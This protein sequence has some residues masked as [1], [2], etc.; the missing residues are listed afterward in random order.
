[1]ASFEQNNENKLWSVRFRVLGDTG[2]QNKRLS[3]Y[4]TKKEAQAAYVEFMSTYISPE[5]DPRKYD[6]TLEQLYTAYFEHSKARLKE[7]T[8]Y[9]IERNYKKHVQP[10]FG[11]KKIKDISK[12]DI[13]K[14]QASLNSADYKY[15][16]KVKIRSLF[17]SILRFGVMYYDLPYNVVSQVESFRNKDIKT[18]M[19]IWSREEFT[20]FILV[21]TDDLLYKTF[22]EFLY[23]T[24]CRKGE[25][26]ALNWNDI[27]FNKKTLSISK[28]LTKKI[29]G[30]PYLITTP[31]NRASVRKILLP[32]NLIAN[33]AAYK[34]SLSTPLPTDFIFGGKLPLAENTIVRRLV[35][36]C[37]ISNVKVIRIHDFRHSHAS[38]LIS[39]G[40]SIVMVAKRLGHSNIEQTLN[41][42]SH[43]MPNQEAEMIGRLNII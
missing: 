34:K 14:W 11:S 21:I 31:K 25:V 8:V 20:R 43:L 19:Q 9:D 4:K 39:M 26:L 3:G 22:F 27:D 36:Y 15:K 30:I 28:S 42:Y 33:L 17:S 1:M 5:T 35:Q 29:V 37:N 2:Q 6:L 24:G 41:T 32:D 13:L 10:V 16:F 12:Q 40:E 38:L 23:L 7:S 18:E